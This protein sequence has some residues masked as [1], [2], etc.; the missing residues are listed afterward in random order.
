VQNYF[1][2]IRRVSAR[3][4]E[5]QSYAPADLAD[6]RRFF[7]FKKHQIYFARLLIREII[8]IEECEKQI[9]ANNLLKAKPELLKTRT[10]RNS[11]CVL[12]QSFCRLFQQFGAIIG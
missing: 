8:K 1:Y 5:N 6:F 10:T 3:S 11:Q 4:A 12:H 9:L 7:G 2:E